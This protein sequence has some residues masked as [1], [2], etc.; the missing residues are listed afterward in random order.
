ML[1]MLPFQN[2]GETGQN[3]LLVSNEGTA[4]KKPVLTDRRTIVKEDQ[5]LA[6]GIKKA[7]LLV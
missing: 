1:C 3:K 4:A 2:L 7:R 5:E 6:N